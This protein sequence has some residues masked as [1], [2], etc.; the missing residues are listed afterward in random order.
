MKRNLVTELQFLFL[1]DDLDVVSDRKSAFFIEYTK[2]GSVKNAH[3]SMDAKEF[4][5][6]SGEHFPDIIG[7]LIDLAVVIHAV[8]R[9]CPT[10]LRKNAGKVHV[11]LPVREIEKFQSE[12]FYSQIRKLLAH[13]TGFSW[14]FDFHQRASRSHLSVQSNLHLVGEANEIALWSGGLDSFAGLFNRMKKYPE[15]NFFLL[16]SGSNN[17]ILGNQNALLKSLRKHNILGENFPVLHRIPIQL[18]ENGDRPRRNRVPRARGVVF[19]MLGVVLSRLQG[20]ENLYIY[21]NGYG[22]I[23][24]PFYESELGV[25]HSRSVSPDTLYKISKLLSFA[26]DEKV[27]IINPFIFSTKGQML[28]SIADTPFSD[29]ASF[30]ISCDSLNRQ[31]NKPAQCGHCSSCILRKQSFIASNFRDLTEY[32][33]P[34]A[35]MPAFK[36]RIL[37]EAF[38][39]QSRVFERI[40]SENNSTDSIWPCFSEKFDRLNVMADI[41]SRTVEL[42]RNDVRSYLIK[43]YQNHLKEWRIAEPILERDFRSC[44]VSESHQF[45]SAEFA[46]AQNEE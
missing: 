6:A 30:T 9:L 26:L 34:H 23:N 4:E 32:L 1:A 15:K 33:I 7:D 17:R 28:A 3:V 24:L 39:N 36:H 10:N 29:Y 13:V 41:I 25:D 44:P 22:A 2:N 16:G 21:E 18:K 42:S 31:R 20:C 5:F 14:H 37:F 19:S 43:L 27:K 40:F 11:V 12:Y 38:A 35:E 45:E 46:I 8:D